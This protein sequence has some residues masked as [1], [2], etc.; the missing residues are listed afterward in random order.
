MPPG[1]VVGCVFFARD[2][3]IGVEELAI[4]AGS[5]LVDHCGLEVEEDGSGDVFPRSM[6]LEEGLC[7]IILVIILIVRPDPIRGESML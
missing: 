3:A 5:D 2:E 1:V 6:F 7:P 4:A